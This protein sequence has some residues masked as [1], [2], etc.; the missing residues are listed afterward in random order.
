M[1]AALLLALVSIYSGMFG[2][3]RVFQIVLAAF[4]AACVFVA[5]RSGETP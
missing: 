2:A 3:P 4:A 5:F 1:G